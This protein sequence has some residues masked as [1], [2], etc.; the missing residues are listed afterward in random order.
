ML[1]LII[2]CKATF[3]I[4]A[5]VST[6]RYCILALLF[7]IT[8]ENVEARYKKSSDKKEFGDI[9]DLIQFSLCVYQLT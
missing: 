7:M 5:L 2:T 9:D 1:C 3:F 6:T 4:K 8:R